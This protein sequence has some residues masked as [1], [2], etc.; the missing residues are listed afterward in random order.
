[1]KILFYAHELL[2][3]LSPYAN[4]I[5]AIFQKF[6]N[7]QLMQFFR[8][9]YFIMYCDFYNWP[10]IEKINIWLMQNL[11]NATFSQNQKSH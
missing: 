11:A 7:I 8:P 9:K 6:P 2:G 4:F 1:M 5:T 3:F 10:N